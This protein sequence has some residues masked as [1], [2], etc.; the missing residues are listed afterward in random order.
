MVNDKDLGKTGHTGHFDGLF[1]FSMILG[2]GL[3]AGGLIKFGH[4]IQSNPVI[5]IQEDTSSEQ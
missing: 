4:F 1:A 2:A 3:L 5:E